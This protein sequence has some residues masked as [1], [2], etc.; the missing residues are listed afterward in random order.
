MW[1]GIKSIFSSTIDF[2][3]T[4][5]GWTPLGVVLNNWKPIGNFF[6][7]LWSGIK[8]LFSDSISFIA[9]IFMDPV[10]SISS[11]WSGLGNWFGGLFTWLGGVFGA[12]VKVI[13]NI[14]TSP[15]KIISNM[16]N[17]LFNWLSN[18]FD[19]IGK[20]V[21]KF[22]SI[23]S[24]IKNFFGFGDNEKKKEKKPVNN[25]SFK[26]GSTMKKVATATAISTSLAASQPSIQPMQPQLKVVQPKLNYAPMPKVQY[27][28]PKEMRQTNHIKVIVNNPSS[29]VDVQKAIVNA[30]N[31]IDNDRGL[32]DE[33]F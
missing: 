12:G 15:I 25:T 17:G 32:S 1:N 26:M 11:A 22:K 33:D 8:T 18:K 31:D 20:A 16:W 30:M 5:L 2:I 27:S 29:T 9:N 4:H 19:W 24:K 3:K 13:T 14:F 23:G 7:N 21:G 28:K 10:Q 6:S